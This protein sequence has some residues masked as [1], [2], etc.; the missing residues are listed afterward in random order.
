MWIHQTTWT[1]FP[2]GN[3]SLD[4]NFWRGQSKIYF[5]EYK[6]TSYSYWLQFQLLLCRLNNHLLW[7][8]SSLPRCKGRNPLWLHYFLLLEFLFLTFQIPNKLYCSSILF[9]EAKYRFYLFHSLPKKHAVQLIQESIT[10][11]SKN[12]L[13]FITSSPMAY[14]WFSTTYSVWSQIV[15]VIC[16]FF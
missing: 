8:F 11:K 5:N 15:I 7:Y 2:F 13:L 12:R 3:I 10:N 14:C 1:D 4:I 6:I 9:T 16:V